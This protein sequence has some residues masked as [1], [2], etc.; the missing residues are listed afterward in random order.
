M[1]R[2][3]KYNPVCTYA[4]SPDKIRIALKVKELYHQKNKKRGEIAELLSL[5]PKTVDRMINSPVDENMLRRSKYKETRGRK[6]K[7]GNIQ[8]IKLK[9][10]PEVD[11][12]IEFCEHDKLLNIKLFPMQKL[13][14]KCFD[15]LELDS[16]DRKIMRAL[17]KGGRTTY[18]G[19]RKYRELV[20]DAGMKGGKTPLAGFI[21]CWEE[22]KLYKIGN[23]Q[24]Y[25]GFLPGKE[26]YILN[27]AVNAE[28]AQQTIFASIRARIENSPYYQLHRPVDSN[29]YRYR[30]SNNVIIRS[31]HSN[32]SS[33]V[34]P[35]NKVVGFDEL[36]R[37]KDRGGKYSADRVYYSLTR[38]VQ[39]FGNEGRLVSISSPLFEGDII[40]EL[41]DKSEEIDDMLGFHLPTWMLNPNLPFKSE[42]MQSELKKNPE[43]F[44]RDFGAEPSASTEAY[45]K[46]PEKVDDCFLKTD[47]ESPMDNRGRLKKDFK[48]RPGISYHMHADPSVRNDAY[49]LAL[50][51]GEGDRVVL[52]L[53]TRFLPGEVHEIDLNEVKEFI[54]NLMKR[55]FRIK[56][57][58]Y[59]TWQAADISQ[60]LEKKG[61]II[62][63]RVI[64]KLEHDFTKELIYA[65]K[66][67]SHKSPVAAKETKGLQLIR[68]SKVDHPKKGSKDI[69]DSIAGACASCRDN[70]HVDAAVAGVD[71]GDQEE[72]E[73]YHY[74]RRSIWA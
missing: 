36:A 5:H 70:P 17:E 48:G 66:L 25:F 3:R 31:G 4:N 34:G 1:A 74:G 11:N 29:E 50:T 56:T 20:V 9:Q 58:S 15:G 30:F 6:K 2:Q 45:Y 32:S 72:E 54:L 35:L 51:H 61:I 10:I 21:S 28:Q 18:K 47:R 44:W 8:P 22:Y 64:G 23:P 60:M 12:S 53:A 37:F 24:K 73:S 62:I 39:P 52:D 49:G 65:G 57:F 40:C 38:T 55:G 69:I 14:M 71:P 43:A 68:G 27:I 46:I 67:D 33:L 42:F 13:I 7:V 19:K 41:Y 26:I 16:D 59:D 63:N